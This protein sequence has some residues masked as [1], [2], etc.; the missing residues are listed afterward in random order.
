VVITSVSDSALL[1][2]ETAFARTWSLIGH[3][4]AGERACRCA[5]WLP[6]TCASRVSDLRRATLTGHGRDWASGFYR[7]ERASGGAQTGHCRPG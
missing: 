3:R 7:A 5:G 2:S 1:S 6:S 4:L